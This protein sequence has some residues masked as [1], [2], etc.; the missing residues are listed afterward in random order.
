MRAL[1]VL[2][3]AWSLAAPAVAAAN[4]WLERRVVNMTHQGGENEYPSNTMYAFRESLALGA[5]TIELDTQPTKDGHLL[6]LHDASVARTT[7]AEGLTYD[8]T[9]AEVQRLDAAHQFIP[10]RGTVAGEPAERYPL[11]GVRT[12]QRQ[13]PLGYTPDDFRIPSLEE[14]LRAFPDIPINIEIKG[15]GDTDLGSFDRN[16]DLLV[17]LLRRVAHRDLIVVSFQQTAVDRFHRQMP[18]VPV[19]PGIAGVA[20]FMATGIAPEG[21]VALQVPPSFGGYTIMTPEFVAR[22]HA[23]GYAVHVWFSGQE[24][25]ERVYHSM[26]DMGADGLMPAKPGDLERVLCARRAPRPPRNSNHCGGGATAG[27]AS[28]APQVRSVGRADRRGRVEV[29]LSRPAPVAHACRGSVRLRDGRRTKLGAA[30]FHFPYG[31]GETRTTLTL[32]RRA[33]RFSRRVEAVAVTR[34][35]GQRGERTGRVVIRR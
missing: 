17:A 35:D 33:R 6:A 9:L 15:R 8:M 31:L 23:S 11:R 24:E 12:G 14:V 28:C 25:S 34:V 13:P 26:L 22:A 4:P 3:A 1:L 27:A 19:A 21:T 16:A 5:D 32:G 7:G 18:E 29:T 30:R 10:G 2:V 20:Q